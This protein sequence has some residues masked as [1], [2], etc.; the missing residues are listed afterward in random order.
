MLTTE[1][2]S[3]VQCTPKVLMVRAN[4]HLFYDKKIA[5][6]LTLTKT[7]LLK[8]TKLMKKIIA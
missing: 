2:D 4:A 6:R 5:L 3:T 7:A 8:L 1:T